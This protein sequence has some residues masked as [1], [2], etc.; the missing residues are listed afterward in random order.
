MFASDH[1]KFASL[2]H[3]SVGITGKIGAWFRNAAASLVS[4]LIDDVESDEIIR[5]A[6]VHNRVMYVGDN[7]KEYQ[8]IRSWMKEKLA[9][10]FIE[11]PFSEFVGE[12]LADYG[13]DCDVFVIDHDLFEGD[14]TAFAEVWGKMRSM[15]PNKPVIVLQGQQYPNCP[16]QI[17]GIQ[18]ASVLQK[19]LTT[20]DMWFGLRQSI[21]LGKLRADD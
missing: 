3:G 4:S 12:V 19:P 17:Y 13:D 20:T 21:Q 7:S 5:D 6:L 1:A 2:D 10:D 16:A 15:F 14:A 8:K 18:G 11:E 9:V